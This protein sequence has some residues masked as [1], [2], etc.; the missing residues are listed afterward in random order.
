MQ[1]INF[2]YDYPFRHA[3]WHSNSRL[4]ADWADR[5]IS[6]NGFTLTPLDFQ[7]TPAPFVVSASIHLSMT[8]TSGTNAS[9]RNWRLY[10][11]NGSSWQ[12]FTFFMPF[13]AMN[14]TVDFLWTGAIN[15]TVTRIAACPASSGTAHWWTLGMRYEEIRVRES[16][17]P[18]ELATND[19]FT[20]FP[21]RSGV[22][23]RPTEIHA[24][25]GGTLRAARNVYANIG[26]T[27]TELPHIHSGAYISTVPDDFRVYQFTPPSTGTYR[28]FQT[29]NSGD[30]V[31]QL[32]DSVF[33]RLHSDAL[34]FVGT[35]TNRHWRKGAV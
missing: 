25:I 27:L 22:A 11:H 3:L 6:L 5:Q 28:I 35:S 30:H 29:M 13:V 4:H 2:Q 19:Y 14:D 33:T 1:A 32:Y 26:G 31:I 23:L 21:N 34:G 16:V 9:N 8:P 17:I 10:F 20:L 7:K 15:S 18:A 12:F 24:N